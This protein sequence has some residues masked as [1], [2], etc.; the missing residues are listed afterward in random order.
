MTDADTVGILST[1]HFEIVFE[2]LIIN[3][4]FTCKFQIPNISVENGI[5]SSKLSSKFEVSNLLS[6]KFDTT[7]MRHEL[8][9]FDFSHTI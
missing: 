2:I 1:F 9:V 8:L 4:I 3:K 7:D 5:V 6:S